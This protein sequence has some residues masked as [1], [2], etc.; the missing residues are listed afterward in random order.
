MFSKL[1]DRRIP[2]T[3]PVVTY[4][5]HAKVNMDIRAAKVPFVLYSGNS[6]PE[7]AKLI[8][9][10]VYKLINVCIPMKEYADLL[11]KLNE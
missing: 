2:N 4:W 9:E 3:L 1:N 6:H 11:M 5:R 10:Y 7:L 8:A